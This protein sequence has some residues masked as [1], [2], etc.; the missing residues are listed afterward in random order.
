ML[1]LTHLRMKNFKSFKQAQIPF[2]D[3]FTAIAGANGSGKSN[4][5]DAVLFALG[6]K[7]LKSLR[8]ARLTDLVH[9][10]AAAGENTP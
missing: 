7:S 3:G 9:S 1:Q 6:E 5:M 4:I 10:G 2:A 8:A